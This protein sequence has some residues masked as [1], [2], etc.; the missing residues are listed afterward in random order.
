M[1]KDT[2]LTNTIVFHLN[3]I[4]YIQRCYELLHLLFQFAEQAKGQVYVMFNGSRDPVIGPDSY[5]Y[6]V[7]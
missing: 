7:I 2:G 3:V 1:A 6:V 5:V 4:I